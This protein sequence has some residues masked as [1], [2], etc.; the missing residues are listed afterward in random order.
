MADTAELDA[1]GFAKGARPLCPFCSKPWTGRMMDL[2]YGAAQYYESC[3][4][5]SYGTLDI[6]CDG[7]NRLIYRKEWG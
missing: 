2:E 7:C 6:T 5:E 3:G 1:D 4:C